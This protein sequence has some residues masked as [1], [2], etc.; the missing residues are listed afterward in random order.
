[1]FEDT[2]T[3]PFHNYGTTQSA[4]QY[5]SIAFVFAVVFAWLHTFAEKFDENGEPSFMHLKQA[6]SSYH[7]GKSVWSFL[8]Y[9]MFFYIHV[10]GL[11]NWEAVDDQR[12]ER[13]NPISALHVQGFAL[14]N[15]D[16][17]AF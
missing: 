4:F 7:A 16:G 11:F 6:I 5:W 2:C 15:I 3:Q 10:L 1:M 14:I 12:Y 17:L 8:F 9:G 13:S